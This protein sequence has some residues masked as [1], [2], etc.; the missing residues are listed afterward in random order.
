MAN[1]IRCCKGDQKDQR[2]PEFMGLGNLNFPGYS[3]KESKIQY[4]N[5]WRKKQEGPFLGLVVVVV[6]MGRAFVKCGAVI[7]VELGR[8][9]VVCLC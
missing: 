8:E 1:R 7:K 6:V 9:D 5:G 2:E 4:R 3:R